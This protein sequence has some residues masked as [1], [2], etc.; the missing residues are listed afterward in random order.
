MRYRYVPT[1][2]KLNYKQLLLETDKQNNRKSL[3]LAYYR[4]VQ[5]P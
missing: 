2:H 5:T 3:L 1:S 4:F